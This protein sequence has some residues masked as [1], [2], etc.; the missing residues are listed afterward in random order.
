MKKAELTMTAIMIQ[1]LL[2]QSFSFLFF[3]QLLLR[4]FEIIVIYFNIYSI[5]FIVFFTL[6]ADSL[7]SNVK[8]QKLKKA[9]LSAT[10]REMNG[11]R[12]CQHCTQ[13]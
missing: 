12:S 7:L 4:L 13:F 2:T 11:V 8:M 3:P 5:L 10:F 1:A 9:M 6:S